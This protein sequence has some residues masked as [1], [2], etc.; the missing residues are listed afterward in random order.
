[1]STACINLCIICNLNACRLA[2]HSKHTTRGHATTTKSCCRSCLIECAIQAGDITGGADFARAKRYKKLTARL[3][4]AQAKSK[5]AKLRSQSMYVMLFL[6]A[7][8]TGAFAAT[9]VL[10]AK[11]KSQVTA[12]WH[13]TV[14][15]SGSCTRHSCRAKNSDGFITTACSHQ[16]CN[17][18]PFDKSDK[19]LKD[20]MHFVLW[21][22][23]SGML[24]NSWAML[25]LTDVA[26][27]HCF[28]AKNVNFAQVTEAGNSIRGVASLATQAREIQVSGSLYSG[29]GSTKPVVI[30][31]QADIV[32]T[33]LVRI[34]QI[35]QAQQSLYLGIGMT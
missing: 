19:I 15:I 20:I 30:R 12:V 3:S 17:V 11:Q 13:L 4:S 26:A 22:D 25:L 14:C 7:I 33:M 1:M 18:L 35:T 9:R 5:M 29:N 8:H 24:F 21:R 34:D 16:L 2:A 10:V 32:V 6:I 28:L 23:N 31:S 27:R